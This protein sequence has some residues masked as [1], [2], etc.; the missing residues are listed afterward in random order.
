[1]LRSFVS[2]VL[3]CI[4]S[5]VTCCRCPRNVKRFGWDTWIRR[6]SAAWK[7]F[8]ILLVL[9]WLSQTHSPVGPIDLLWIH[10]LP[11]QRRSSLS[12]LTKR[13]SLLTASFTSSNAGHML[14]ARSMGR[15]SKQWTMSYMSGSLPDSSLRLNLCMRLMREK[16]A[17]HGTIS[18]D[19]TKC[20]NRCFRADLRSVRP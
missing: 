1:M 20:G 12:V 16:T 13:L 2:P 7:L 6:R 10:C 9:F 5:V 19:T 17:C 14:S 18:K 11:T 4:H 8:K 15:P 3:S